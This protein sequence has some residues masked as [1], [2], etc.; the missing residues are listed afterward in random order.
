MSSD[1]GSGAPARVPRR[2]PRYRVFIATGVVLGIAVAAVLTWS[3]SP[4]LG[5][6]Y[7][8]VF[9]YLATFCALLGALVGGAVAVAVESFVN[10]GSGGRR[11]GPRRHRG[12]GRSP[13]H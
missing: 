4:G 3:G 7:G 5:F 12:R 6:G 9:G 1:P 11:R 10:R 13:R 2:T 8:A